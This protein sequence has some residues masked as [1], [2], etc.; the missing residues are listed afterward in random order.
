MK[1]FILEKW[2]DRYR[3]DHI[4]EEKPDSTETR[5][6]VEGYGM[7]EKKRCLTEDE[8]CAMMESK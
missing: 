3:L 2:T 7:V 6:S 4:G 5:Y 8:V 1:I